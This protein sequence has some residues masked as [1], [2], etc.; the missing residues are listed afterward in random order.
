MFKP[1]RITLAV[2][3]LSLGMTSMVASA[4]VATVN[5]VAI[6]DSRMNAAL[7]Q[8]S[9]RGQKDSPELR[10]RIKE[11]LVQDEILSQEAAK[12][13]LDKSPEF[14]AQLDMARQQ[15]LIGALGNDIM[16]KI[17]VSDADLK[18]D[19]DKIKAGMSPKK[20]KARHILVKTDAE[21]NAIL[22]EL[23]KGKKFEDLAKAKS[24]DKG[25]A[26]QGGSLGG[27][28]GEWVD[29]KM[30]VPA[31]AAAMNTMSKGQISKEP[32]K[33]EYGF[34]IIKIDDVQDNKAPEFKDVKEQLAEKKKQEQAQKIVE[35]LTK[36]AKVE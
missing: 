1:T 13:G 17:Q 35:D 36:K 29:P 2:A 20:Y 8:L 31:F 18:A 15:M 6:P 34:H 25:S 3:A 11:K 28:Q 26:V 27:P 10:A 32:V 19:Y 30:F 7:K 22:A 12:R 24:M 33:T 4:A 23:K 21:A 16:G 9:Q 14:Q 5:G